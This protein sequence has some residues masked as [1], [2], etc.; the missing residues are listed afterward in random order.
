MNTSPDAFFSVADLH[1]YYGDSYVLQGIDLQVR[2]GEVLAVLGRNGVGKTTLAKSIMGFVGHRQGAIHLQGA[3]ISRH[4]PEARS[5]AGIALVPQ[6]RRTFKSL[7]VAE[8]LDLAA[9][10]KRFDQDG[11]AW[12]SEEVYAAFPRLAERRNN[13]AGKLSGGEQQMLAVGRALVGNPRLLVLD[14]PTEGLSPLLV[15]ELHAVLGKVK[16]RRSTLILIEQRLKF[17]LALADRVI[18][19]SKGKVVFESTPEA[20]DA[21]PDTKQ[22]YLGI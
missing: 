14:E 9:H 22:R 4:A 18:I 8:T 2:P 3:D 19:L 15:Q 17:A 6:G 21:D 5:R 13:R 16:A 12:S 20:L 11:L 10:L 7:S 1:T